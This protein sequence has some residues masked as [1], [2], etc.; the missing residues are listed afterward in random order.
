MQLDRFDLARKGEPSL[1]SLDPTG[2]ISVPDECEPLGTIKGEPMI[3]KS[4]KPTVEEEL[5]SISFRQQGQMVPLPI[6]YWIVDD[7][8]R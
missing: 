1:G 4:H 5:R 7:Q 8:L 3:I 6:D 2:S